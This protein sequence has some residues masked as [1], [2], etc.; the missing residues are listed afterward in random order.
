MQREFD[1][2]ETW[3]WMQ[4]V[5]CPAAFTQLTRRIIVVMYRLTY[6]KSRVP[7]ELICNTVPKYYDMSANV[8]ISFASF[9][10]IEQF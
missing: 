3:I 9:E 5:G 7:V 6:E 2:Y 10:G 4:N 1:T 8:Y